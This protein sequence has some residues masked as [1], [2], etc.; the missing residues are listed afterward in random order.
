MNRQKVVHSDDEAEGEAR[1]T[2]V[3]N[4]HLEDEDREPVSFTALRIQWGNKAVKDSVPTEGQVFLH[5]ST[6]DGLKA[7]MIQVTA[8]RFD[9]SRPKPVIL[10]LSSKEKRWI[11]LKKPRNSYH[12]TIRTVMI[13][14]HFLHLVK[15]NPKILANSLWNSM[16]KDREL[17]LSKSK[18]S[19]KDL[20]DHIP[21]IDEA[22]KRDAVLAKSQLLLTI[23]KEKPGNTNLSD[24]GEGINEAS[25]E[26]EEEDDLSS[27]EVCAIC[28]DG[29]N[30]TCCEGPCMRSFHARKTDGRRSKCASLGFAQKESIPSFYCKNCIYKQH[31]CFACGKLGSSDQ[32][33]GAEVI[34]CASATCEHFY[35]PHCVAKLL[36]QV[37]SHVAEEIERNVSNT[38]SFTCPVHY[39]CVCKEVE[40]AMEP[41]LQLAV[42]RRC[43]KSYHRKC[44]PRDI[45]LEDEDEDKDEEVPQRAWEGLL[46]NKRILI[47]CL[48]HEIDEKLGTPLRDHIKFPNEKDTVQEISVSNGKM[49]P[50]TKEGIRSNKKKGDVDLPVESTPKGS[51][52]SLSTVK[53]GSK[54]NSKKMSSGSNIAKQPKANGKS[55][56]STENANRSK[57]TGKLSPGEVDSKNSPE[58]MSS[59]SNI[60]KKPKANG[61]SGCS[62]ENAN[63]SKVTG[64]L[65][66]VEVDSKNSPEKMSSGS[67]IAKKLE[68]KGKS[69]CLTKDTPGSKVSGKLSPGKGGSKNNSKKM[70]SGSNVAKLPKANGKSGCSTENANSSKVTGKPFPG[71]VDSK[72]SPEKLSSGSNIAKKPEAN[73]KSGCL[74]NHT[75]GSNES[76][77]LSPGKGGGKNNTGKMT[78]PSNIT[79]QPKANGKSGS[80][81]IKNKSTISKKSE[82]PESEE[83]Q[84]QPIRVL[85]DND[86]K[87]TNAVVPKGKPPL[88]SFLKH[89]AI[90]KELREQQSSQHQAVEME[91]RNAECLPADRNTDDNCGDNIMPSQE[92]PKSPDGEEAQA[93]MNGCRKRSSHHCKDDQDSQ[94]GPECKKSKSEKTSSTKRKHS[95]ENGGSADSVVSSAKRQA[96]EE[97]HREE[98]D[99]CQIESNTRRSVGNTAYDYAKPISAFESSY[100]LTTSAIGRSG[101][102]L[103]E[104]CH[105]RMGSLGSEPPTVTRNGDDENRVFELFGFASGPN[106]EYA[107]KHS[108]GWIEE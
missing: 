99:K 87:Q 105:F 52:D 68:A 33:K 44:L 104:L 50:A 85:M 90:A 55:G 9:L 22:A 92:P 3:S 77:K 57:V 15:R 49:K 47:Y 96:V 102:N 48:N 94:E 7:V 27:H 17:C 62:T 76:G 19:E 40:N 88:L 39:C 84:P 5:G 46:P 30:L 36:S 107:R 100:K 72:N 75:P 91:S 35:H 98:E 26:S 13:T 81:L 1:L 65:S 101:P 37:T 86:S 82:M 95:E 21:L 28:D 79:K 31:Q 2:C 89:K 103:E 20:L 18:P 93:S 61:K 51:D 69:S 14:V 83:S 56:C 66:P 38:S 11:E 12:D 60:A 97:L 41:E 43:P 80:G 29:G 45:P 78:S 63:R 42:C 59:G 74:T 73:G 64:K 32:V 108:A 23:L 67:N 58:K 10:L 4:Y 24:S 34:K 106:L 54:N 70:S 53:V 16:F 71:E 8:W 6:D 25:E